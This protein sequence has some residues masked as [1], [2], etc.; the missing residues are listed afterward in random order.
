[1]Q[2]LSEFVDSSRLQ[3]LQTSLS[4]FFQT[5][6]SKD[7]W[8]NITI[9]LSARDEVNDKVNKSAVMA[10]IEQKM[11]EKSPH[12]LIKLSA[13]QARIYKW[14]QSIDGF[15]LHHSESQKL[16]FIRCN[17]SSGNCYYPEFKTITHGITVVL[18]NRELTQFLAV[19]ENT[20]QYRG[21]KA[22][23]GGVDYEVENERM[24]AVR[25]VKE[26]TDITLSENQLRLVSLVSTNTIPGRAP[27]R[28]FVF[29][30]ICDN[31]T[32]LVP[33][34]QVREIKEAS[35]IKVEDFLSSELPL[36][37]AKEPLVLKDVVRTAMKCLTT[38]Q[39]W[40]SKEA[41][42]GSFYW[43]SPVNSSFYSI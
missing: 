16:V 7:P 20:N 36:D 19:K 28:N 38:D 3:P 42:W 39:G 24:A 37:N 1:M 25:E 17:H 18:F 15:K 13:N 34:P 40:I 9:D 31:A 41:Y 8:Q 4:S 11:A 43:N 10:I 35:W 5:C 32:E 23:T 29:A 12:L 33:K 27:D 22:P 6:S 21:W 14:I 26:E 30:G 2:T